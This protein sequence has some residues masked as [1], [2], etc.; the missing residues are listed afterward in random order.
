MT[1][2]R[3]TLTLPDDLDDLPGAARA[4]EAAGFSAGN[5]YD[6]PYPPQEWLQ[7]GGHTAADP[8]VSLSFA[9]AATSTLRLH[10]N[11]LVPAYR[12]PILTAHA[13]ATLDA[14]SGGRVILGVAVGYLEGEFESLGVDFHRRGA[15]LDESIERIRAAWA[16]GI[17]PQPVQQPHPPIWFG[18]NSK[19]SIRRVVAVGSGWM[20]FPATVEAAAA[21][22]TVPMADIDALARSI[23]EL[24]AAADAAGRTD[25][26]DI[27]ATPFTHPAW[28]R[29][30]EPE[31]LLDEA[32]KLESVGITWLSIRLN[33]PSRA[34]FLEEVERFGTEVIRAGGYA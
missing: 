30:L 4:V 17:W 2:L 31:Q 5:V 8:F 34:A 15:L 27:C 6:H 24:H 20:P 18:G 10:T 32:V 3:F 29:K 26:I 9:A 21:V 19:A 23:E 14:L 1:G 13:V 33:T 16:E 11:I 28:K 22:R 7:H 25:P 12:N